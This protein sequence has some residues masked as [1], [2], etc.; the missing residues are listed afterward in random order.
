MPCHIVRIPGGGTAIVRTAA[1]RPRK[2]SVC[3]RQTKDYRLC[4]YPMGTSTLAA[5]TG[6][7]KTCDAVLCQSCTNHREPDIDYC[8]L[9]AQAVDGK[10]RL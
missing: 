1:P 10:L 6:G 2:C 7:P 9:H 5:R 4:D 8:P 3:G